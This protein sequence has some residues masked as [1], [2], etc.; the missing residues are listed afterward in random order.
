MPLGWC[1]YSSRVPL[2]SSRH[3]GL[4]REQVA[5]SRLHLGEPES[6]FST[7]AQTMP[8]LLPARYE[9]RELLFWSKVLWFGLG[10]SMWVRVSPAASDTQN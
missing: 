9:I 10:Q 7:L 8:T 4:P 2:A 3:L 1:F 5:M 6:H